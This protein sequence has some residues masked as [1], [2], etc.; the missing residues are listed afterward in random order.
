MKQP[1]LQR[2]REFAVSVV[3]KLREAGFE[4]LWAGGCVRDELLGLRPKD[5]DVATSATPEQIREAF[6]HRRTLAIGAAFGVI[7]VLGPSGAGQIDVATFRQETGY[8]DGRHPDQVTFSTPELDAGRRDFTINGL[9][10]DPIEQRVIDYIDGQQDLEQKI[11]R[12]IGDAR[13]RFSEDKLRMLRAVRFAA[14]FE[15]TLEEETL[16][17]VREMAAEVTVVS[18]ERIGAEVRQMLVH[19]AR[20]TAVELLRT[21]KLLEVM[22]P[23]VAAILTA[24]TD[25]GPAWRETLRVLDALDEPSFPLVL[26]GLLHRNSDSQ[27]AQA[28]GRRL[29]TPTKETE[30]TAWLLAHL[31]AI[32]DAKNLAWPRL[33]PLLV[34]EGTEELLALYEAITTPENEHLAH[35]RHRLDLPPEEL[36]PKPL[37]SGDDLIAHGIRPG[38]SFGLL[39][40]R[41]RDAQLE[42]KIS[43]VEEAMALVDRLLAEGE[44]K[45]ER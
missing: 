1:D 27:V 12:A 13:K 41:A 17:A 34:S 6:G 37:I 14:T 15:F 36:N 39:L 42:K 21:S 5:Y 33:Q 43:T 9:F 32:G 23:E 7:V 35:C 20:C 22:L 30:R 40:T 45:P 28:V 3:K 4:A 29:R 16:A 11:V 19:A 24:D 44:A 2:Q 10:F 8:S 38:E 31:A 18:A 25:G 26:A